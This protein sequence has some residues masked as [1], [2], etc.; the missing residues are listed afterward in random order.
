MGDSGSKDRQEVTFS[1]VPKAVISRL[2]LYLRELQQLLSEGKQT[3]RSGEL[4]S[5]LGF[6]DAQV[7][8][9]LTYFGQFGY[10]G[11]GYR[12]EELVQAIRHI[13]GTDIEWRVVIVGVGNLGQALLGYKGF[14]SQGFQ[15]VAALD[16]DPQKTGTIVEGIKIHALDD[17]AGLVKQHRVRLGM[18]AVPA[19]SA[20]SVVD[21][22]VDAGIDGIVNFAPVTINL[23]DHVSHVGVD[24]AS[25]LEQI[26]FAVAKR[27]QAQ[28]NS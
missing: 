1:T 28:D 15:I 13:L 21:Q 4:G 6:T 12:S 23:P 2:S 20:Q 11:I 18:V 3:V 26:T 17:L 25:E 16:A 8:K 19:P 22:L 27:L 24:L 5:R 14:S 7:R 9:D 10:P